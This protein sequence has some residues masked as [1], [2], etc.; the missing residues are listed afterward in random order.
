MKKIAVCIPTLNES[1]NIVDTTKKV[2]EGLK[3]YRSKYITYIV[4]ADNS[5]EDDTSELFLN[6][7]TYVKKVSIISGQKGKGNNLLKF[8]KFCKE[9]GIDYAITIDADVKSLESNWI[10]KFLS[11]II[12]EQYDYITPLYKRSR[13]EGSTTNHFAFPI[14]YACT[15]KYIR[16]PI[17][18]DFA[19]NKR[20]IDI[21]MVQPV[22][23]AIK[24]YGIDIFM[25]LNACFNNLK[26]KQIYLGTKIHNPSY[27]KMEGMFKEVLEAFVFTWKHLN[28]SNE[29]EISNFEELK[30]VSN[31]II[32]SKTF[33]HK[34]QAKEMRAL[35]SSKVDSPN[36]RELWITEM[37]KMVKSIENIGKD[38]KEK[39]FN[40]FMYRAT[41]F[42]L[43]AQYK[44]AEQCETEILE[45]A[46]KIIE[47]VRN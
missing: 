26:I 15:G 14:I 40:V 28:K 47:K 13:F 6:T 42:W 46:Q 3:K 18:G 35:Y 31:N 29:K 20:F 4:N 41:D 5:S 2:D 23:E 10:N 19:F 27:N 25:T 12:N 37:V 1:Q 22:N 24:Q 43:K 30:V 44:G 9:E 11:P 7:P 8:F 21:I 33:K 38:E 45:Q 16:Q 34:Q 36:G 17:A 32:R 39:I